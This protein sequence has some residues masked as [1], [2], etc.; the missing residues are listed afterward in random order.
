MRLTTSERDTIR[1][2]VRS[3]AGPTTRVRLFGS[4]TDDSARGG[5]ID[6]L[7]EVDHPVPSAV[8]L[9]ARIGARLQQGLVERHI[10]VVLAAPNLSDSTIHRV[11]RE[12]GIEL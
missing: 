9:G 7:V 1:E 4:R 3:I 10:D 11:A 8:R 2:T 12:T 6:L 5:D